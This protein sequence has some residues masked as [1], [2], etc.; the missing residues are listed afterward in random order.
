MAKNAAS[1][2]GDTYPVRALIDQYYRVL[3]LPAQVSWLAAAGSDMLMVIPGGCSPLGGQ[4]WFNF[5]TQD[6]TLPFYWGE[7][8]EVRLPAIDCPFGR[9]FR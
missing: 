8:W 7:R 4:P 3:I 1:Y 9:G 5:T 2:I 6:A